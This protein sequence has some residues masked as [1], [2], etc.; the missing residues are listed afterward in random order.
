MAHKWAGWL[1]NSGCFGVSK[2]SERGEGS[3]VAHKWAG[4]LHNPCRLGGTHRF[5]A[6]GKIRNVP[7]VGWVATYHLLCGGSPPL[8]SRGQDHEWPTSGPGGYITPNEWR[9]R[10]ASEQGAE[11][12]VAHKWA[13]WLHITCFVGGPQG[14][15]GVDRIKSGPQMGRVAT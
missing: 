8:Q 11:S 6:E 3:Q 12:E 5:K 14:F 9:L 7:Q 10:T 4:W 15:R 1:Y 13:G 2:A